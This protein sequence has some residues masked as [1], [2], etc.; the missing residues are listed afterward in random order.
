MKRAWA[1]LLVSAAT[2]LLV[3]AMTALNT[4]MI[5]TGKA[6]IPSKAVLLLTAVGGGVAFARTIQQA[7]RDKELAKVLFGD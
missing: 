5:A 7:I 1:I 6:E 2:D 3:T 4:A